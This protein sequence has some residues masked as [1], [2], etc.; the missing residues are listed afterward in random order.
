[1]SDDPRISIQT[2]AGH[3][4]WLSNTVDRLES[5]VV[6]RGL[7]KSAELPTRASYNGAIHQTM[8]WLVRNEARIRRFLPHAEEIE[9]LLALEPEVRAAILKHG[10]LVAELAVQMAEREAVS[11]AG[12]PAR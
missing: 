6:K 9:Q 7:C 3:V 12:G 8:Q 10:P 5:E 4:A 1:M 2:Q 11:A